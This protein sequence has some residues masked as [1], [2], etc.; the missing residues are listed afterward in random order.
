MSHFKVTHRSSELRGL[1]HRLH[2]L[3]VVA[4][5]GDKDLKAGV[6]GATAVLP[7]PTAAGNLVLGVVD[8][9]NCVACGAEEASRVFVW[10]HDA[11]PKCWKGRMK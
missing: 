9:L 5:V 4:R 3:V 8:R 6:V 10:R 7:R 2:Y 11:H 1:Q